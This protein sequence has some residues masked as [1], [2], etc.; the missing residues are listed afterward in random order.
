[1]TEEQKEN[2][3]IS[4]RFLGYGD[5][6]KAVIYY[7]GLE[8]A[9]PFKSS[10]EIKNIVYT[11]NSFLEINNDRYFFDNTRKNRGVK[12]NTESFQ[13]YLS[14]RILKDFFNIKVLPETVDLYKSG[15]YIE[16]E[17]RV[18]SSN[19][20]PLGASSIASN[21]NISLTGFTDKNAYYDYAWEQTPVPRK[22]V[23]KNFIND[24][25]NKRNNSDYFIFIMG[26]YIYPPN[27]GRS[28]QE[29]LKQICEELGYKFGKFIFPDSKNILYNSY[30]STELKWECSDCK[31]IWLIGHPSKGASDERV[32]DRIVNFLIN[33]FRRS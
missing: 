13:A 8:E 30:T 6:N 19:T 31:R 20:Y 16:N 11:P 27:K 25:K 17:D 5:P 12:G 32:A 10:E 26:N 2:I 1:M 24:I 29:R 28:A 7:F 33:N 22:E 9:A 21:P 18:L 15:Y 4:N 23:L 3:V 14:Y